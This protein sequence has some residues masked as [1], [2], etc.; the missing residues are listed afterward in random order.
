MKLIT[1]CFFMAV[2]GWANAQSENISENDQMMLDAAEKNVMDYYAPENVTDE[3]LDDVFRFVPE[4]AVV[5]S[6][7]NPLLHK[8]ASTKVYIRVNKSSQ[9]MHVYVHGQHYATWKVS[10]G[11]RPR[12]T[13]PTGTWRP[14]RMHSRYFSRKYNNA[15]MPYSIFY[16]RGFAIHGTND[17]KR[18]GRPA[19]HGCVRLHPSNARTL[20]N[21]V[22][23]YKRAHTRIRVH[24]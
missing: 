19:S 12:Y 8:V 7:A 6:E 14:T 1:I 3:S 17:L 5:R 15:P 21:L 4:E 22:M 13:T 2:S 24:W 9:R 16:Y 10:T 23:K 11:R 20:F 18:L